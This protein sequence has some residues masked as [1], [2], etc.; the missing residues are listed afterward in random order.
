MKLTSHIPVGEIHSDSL[1]S[2]VHNK[3]NRNNK[4]A[5]VAST[6][7][8]GGVDKDD[9]R[10]EVWIRKFEPR[11]DGDVKISINEASKSKKR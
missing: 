1:K 2:Q 6:L 5:S 3:G 7:P 9:P 11:K 8:A 4:G 10:A